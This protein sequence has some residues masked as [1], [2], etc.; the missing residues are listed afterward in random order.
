MS[1]GPH[2]WEAAFVA[3][4]AEVWPPDERGVYDHM[5]S[6]A[7]Q[8]TCA[9][10]AAL[11]HAEEVDGG[12]F[13][14]VPPRP[15]DPMPRWDDVAVTALG[16]ARQLNRVSFR[17][18]EGRMPERPVR[19]DQFVIRRIGAP[20]PPP[21][22]V[23]AAHGL[24]PA[25][26]DDASLRALAG[27]GLVADGAWTDAAVPVLWRKQPEAWALDVEGTPAFVAAV[28]DAV[29]T[30]PAAVAERIARAVRIA[31]EDVAEARAAFEARDA[32]LRGRLRLDAFVR[33]PRTDADLR[34]GLVSTRR[35]D[36][37]WLFY[38]RWRLGDGWLGEAGRARALPIFHDPL[39]IAM[40][41]AVV[42]RLH[43]EA[44][45]MAER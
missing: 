12:A 26:L 20:P 8:M 2:G 32:E 27:L 23:A 35:N 4:V 28:G 22:N 3:F 11:G 29:G 39:A 6:S 16:L 24:G 44:P 38:S 13:A 43:P 9:A 10:L 33:G 7:F 17:N 30:V 36:L 18:A 31:D 14:L 34:R 42:A 21:P 25:R 45:E 40:R 41:R 15:A 37:D 5:F 19:A 1:D